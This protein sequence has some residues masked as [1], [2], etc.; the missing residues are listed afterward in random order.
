[1]FQGAQDQSEPIYLEH[2]DTERLDRAVHPMLAIFDT[3]ER[4]EPVKL[5]EGLRPHLRR[6]R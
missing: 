2:R 5:P 4:G 1:M 6:R 3:L